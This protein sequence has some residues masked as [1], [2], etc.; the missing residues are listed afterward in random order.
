M[1]H[2]SLGS[3]LD[4]ETVSRRE[5]CIVCNLYIKLVSLMDLIGEAKGRSLFGH[6]VSGYNQVRPA[7]PEWIYALL[8]E[9]KALFPD[10]ATLEVGAGSGLATRQLIKYGV[11]PLT[12]LEPEE[13]FAPLLRSLTEASTGTAD[14]RHEAFEDAH[15][16]PSSFDLVVVATAFHWLSP[17]TRVK[18]LSQI[19]KSNG[20]VALLWNVFGDSSRPD[21]F[22]E[23]TVELLGSLEISPST[24]PD[25]VPFALDREAREKEFLQ[26]GSFELALYAES[27]WQLELNPAQ[28]KLLYEGFSSIARLPETKRSQILAELAHVAETK[29]DGLV[30]RNMSSLLYLF[31]RT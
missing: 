16:E 10:A 28:V 6:N 4:L 17:N 5:G 27:R 18:K 20:Y 11:S 24:E 31:R 26:G 3:L 19:V 2:A 22:H 13:K 15:F 23:A 8:A 25:K 7:Y 9:Q 12:L 14:I 30:T 29:F 1:S 21:P